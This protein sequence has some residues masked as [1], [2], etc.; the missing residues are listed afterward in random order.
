MFICLA[1]ISLGSPHLREAHVP[2]SKCSPDLSH[3]MSILTYTAKW[4]L[5]SSC[6]PPRPARVV[7][8][9]TCMLMSSSC[10]P[11]RPARVVHPWTRMPMSSSGGPPRPTRALAHQGVHLPEALAPQRDAGWA[12]KIKIKYE[13]II[14]I[15]NKPYTGI[16]RTYYW[17]ASFFSSN[18]ARLSLQVYPLYSPP[19]IHF[20]SLLQ[21]LPILNVNY[22]RTTFRL[23]AKTRTTYKRGGKPCF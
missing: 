1:G 2:V 23:H 7:L 4:L 17:Q 18:L 13:N 12:H 15:K 16:S 21:Y 22:C 3:I 5:S 20:L 14:K 10:G 11:P 19:P 6:G 9:R 8:P